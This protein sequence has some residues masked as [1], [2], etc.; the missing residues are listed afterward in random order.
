M[1]GDH[2]DPESFKTRKGRVGGYADYL[3]GK[4]IEYMNAYLEKNLALFYCY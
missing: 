3:C 1:P 2:S 4:E